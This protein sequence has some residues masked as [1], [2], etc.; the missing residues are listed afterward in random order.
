MKIVVDAMGGDYAPEVVITGAVTAVQEYKGIEI[1]LVGDQAKI[2]KFLTDNKF[3]R[4][5][6][7]IQHASEVIEMHDS[8]ATSVR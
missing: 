5:R 3:S 6:I 2:E 8:P 1:V 7:S 4:E